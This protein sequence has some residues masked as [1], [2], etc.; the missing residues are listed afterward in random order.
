MTTFLCHTLCWNEQCKK[1]ILEY[2]LL[3]ASRALSS[4]QFT[5]QQTVLIHRQSRHFQVYYL[6][7]HSTP[8]HCCHLGNA[9]IADSVVTA[10][11]VHVT[12]VIIIIMVALC[13]WADH[14]ILPC[15][16]C[17]SSS[18]FFPRLMS[19]VGDWMS[20]TLPHMVWP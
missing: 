7:T 5:I 8:Y 15:G 1:T 20:T 2:H 12:N 11:T 6:R 13:N 10:S 18:F 16:F 19:A 17:L 14:Y 4:D 9:G 3:L